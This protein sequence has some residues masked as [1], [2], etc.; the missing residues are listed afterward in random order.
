[1]GLNLSHA[2]IAKE[3]DLNKDDVHQV[4]IQLRQGIVSKKPRVL[5]Q[6]EVECDQVYVIAGHK[7]KP[8]SVKEKA[9]KADGD[10]SR[11]SGAGAL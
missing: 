2:Q 4:T 5:L 7:G 1:M 10:A 9:A 8:D 3:L 6:G 11:A